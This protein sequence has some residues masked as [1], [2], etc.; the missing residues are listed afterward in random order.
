MD[1]EHQRSFF[2]AT[3]ASPQVKSSTSMYQEARPTAAS[4][5]RCARNGAQSS[6]KKATSA[7]SISTASSTTTTVCPFRIPP[8]HFG[9]PHDPSIRAGRRAHSHRRRSPGTRHRRPTPNGAARAASS[10]AFV[11]SFPRSPSTTSTSLDPSPESTPSSSKSQN[12]NGVHIEAVK[13]VWKSPM[14]DPQ[15]QRRP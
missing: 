4:T 14:A 13:E 5:K 11:S 10:S 9:Y 3:S 6:P 8:S 12:Y 7:T 2:P 1:S 15:R